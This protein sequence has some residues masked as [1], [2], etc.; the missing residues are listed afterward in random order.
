MSKGDAGRG[1]ERG[2]DSSENVTQ[3]TSGSY[4]V[5]SAVCPNAG[6]IG[7]AHDSK[8]VQRIMNNGEYYEV[9]YY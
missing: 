5:C 6:K 4:P 2:D 1:R 7:I 8:N 9:Q 3:K